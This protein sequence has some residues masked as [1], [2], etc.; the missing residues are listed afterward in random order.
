MNQVAAVELEVNI[1]CGIC[2][3][4]IRVGDQH[5]QGCGRPV[6][7]GDRA[8]LQ[9]RLEG[10]DYQAYERGKKVRDAAKWIGVLAI[11][12]AVS[13]VIMFF[14]QQSQTSAAL[15][16]LSA[17]QDDEVLAPIEGKT[18]TAGELRKVVEREP[19]Q[20]LIVNV[21]VAGLMLGLWVWAKRAPL[22]AIACAFALFIV[23]HVGSAIVDPTSIAKGFIVKVAAIAVLAKGLKAALAARA[24][25]SRP[26]A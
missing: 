6:D 26:G 21:I 23:V 24:V 17:F 15:A 19:L 22:P 16:K 20:I 3:S 1:P 14:F 18:Y 25:M 4:V 13:G 2:P 10:S 5:C 9:V 12:F 11:L 8:T 7:D